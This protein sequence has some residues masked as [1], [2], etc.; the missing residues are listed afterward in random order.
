M[1]SIIVSTLCSKT[2]ATSCECQ[3]TYS[4]FDEDQSE[5]RNRRKLLQDASHLTNKMG[6]PWRGPTIGLCV[7]LTDVVVPIG[8]RAALSG[9]GRL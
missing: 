5:D 9:I 2:K 8:A 4:N 6:D 7:G 3:A 1:P